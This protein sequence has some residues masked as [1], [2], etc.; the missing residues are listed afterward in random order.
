MTRK[1]NVKIGDKARDRVS[2]LTGTVTC[3]KEHLFGNLQF[4]I[5]THNEDG[6]KASESYAID[7]QQLELVEEQVIDA[8]PTKIYND[9]ELGDLVKDR[10]TKVEG[11]VTSIWHWLNGCVEA[12]IEYNDDGSE[13]AVRSAIDRFE[14]K[15]K[16]HIKLNKPGEV[17]KVKRK[18]GGPSMRISRES[19]K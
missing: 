19:L 17:E 11:T 2:G 16:G 14:I 12:F 10:I 1:Y 3:R 4:I 18:T 9:V 8:I 5:E 13:K 7:W 6:D 15:K